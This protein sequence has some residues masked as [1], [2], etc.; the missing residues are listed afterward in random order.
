[1]KWGGSHWGLKKKFLIFHQH[2]SDLVSEVIDKKV[3]ADGGIN[4]AILDK[5]LKNMELLLMRWIDYR[6]HLNNFPAVAQP[7][8][9]EGHV[10]NLAGLRR[11][12]LFSYDGK[13]WCIQNGFAFPIECTCLHGW[14]M[15]LMGKLIIQ[16]G[17]P[18]KVK[19]FQLMSGSEMPTKKIVN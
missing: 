11:R 16:D 9:E 18:M 14:W 8:N 17:K 12:N 4:S 2:L 7:L 19:L 3:L 5:Q 15:W 6:D 10:L 1:M 13:F